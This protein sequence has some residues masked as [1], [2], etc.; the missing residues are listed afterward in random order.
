MEFRKNIY[1]Y[2]RR[3]CNTYTLYKNLFKTD[4]VSKDISKYTLKGLTH[5]GR[6]HSYR[7]EDLGPMVYLHFKIEGTKQYLRDYIMVDEAQD[8]SFVQLATLLRIAKNGNITIA[9]DLA[10]S[11]IPPFYIRDWDDVFT[12]IK[13]ITKK[14]T[15][16][17]QLQKCYRTTIEIVEFANSVFKDRFPKSY[18]LPEGVLRHG[19][20]VKVLE[21]DTDISNLNSNDLKELVLLIKEQFSKGAVTCALLCRNRS[22]ASKLY[23][24]F[25]EYEDIIGRRVIS[26]KENDYNSGLLVLPIENAKGLE[27]DS[28]IFADLNSDY[29]S[30]TELDIRLL[31][32]GITRALH[33]LF[34]VKR[35]GDDIFNV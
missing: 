14:D 3:N 13:D 31:Y 1:N 12:L 28:V 29:Y 19:D 32:V 30:N 4:L 21:Y 5:K 6:I 24:I 2:L 25:K 26:Y 11:I 10:Q 27:F 17:Y 15:E 34:I 20:D 16:Y 23:S 7:M 8:I 33:R 22:H 35:K 18:K 9:G